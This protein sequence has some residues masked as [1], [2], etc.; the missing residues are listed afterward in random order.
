MLV[1]GYPIPKVEWMRYKKILKA[2]DKKYKMHSDRFSYYHLEILHA[3]DQDEGLYQL[4][5][6]NENGKVCI[7]DIY[8]YQADSPVFLQTYN[9]MKVKSYQDVNLTCR[10]DGLPAPEIK[11]FKDKLRLVESNRIKIKH[12]KPDVWTIQIQKAFVS[13]SG[14]YSCVVKNMAGEAMCSC[15]LVI[16]QDNI[17]PYSEA[18]NVYSSSRARA[19]SVDY[20][21]KEEEERKNE[22]DRKSKEP[23]FDEI[24]EEDFD[25]DEDPFLLP[26][27]DS[28]LLVRIREYKRGFNYENDID[29]NNNN[30]TNDN[31]DSNSGKKWGSFAIKENAKPNE[32]QRASSLSKEIKPSNENNMKHY[33]SFD[34]LNSNEILKEEQRSN[35]DESFNKTENESGFKQSNEFKV[36]YKTKLGKNKNSIRDSLEALKAS[37]NKNNETSKP[38]KKQQSQPEQVKIVETK[39]KQQITEKSQ[40]EINKI[41]LSDKPSGLFIKISE[42]EP[43]KPFLTEAQQKLKLQ[44]ELEKKQQEQLLKEKNLPGKLDISLY[45]QNLD[46]NKDPLTIS[47]KEK[48]NLDEKVSWPFYSFDK[49]ERLAPIIREK[50]KDVFLF[51]GKTVTLEC[52]IEGNPEPRIFWYHENQIIRGNDGRITT[53]KT[54]D[55]KLILTIENATKNDLGNLIN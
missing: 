12:T 23:D 19:E 50:L 45:E 40:N 10:I 53:S 38:Q 4:V 15:N 21:I 44:Q 16:E 37:L 24:Q 8:L 5:A 26:V 36:D 25:L 11:F 29:N 42:N 35:S 32:N 55:G 43:A 47:K 22:N 17:M 41:N 34:R 49:S 52:K 54:L 27:V 28:S 18:R 30:S 48:S 31:N 13:D 20:M 33:E 1:F 2:D 9:D 14:L 3:N 39:S 6:T 46:K 7:H 51:V